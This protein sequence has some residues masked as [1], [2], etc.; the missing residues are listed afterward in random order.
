MKR[1]QY[2]DT[3]LVNLIARKEMS[4]CAIAREL[5]LSPG[6]VRRIANGRARQD[7]QPR[8]RSLVNMHHRLARRRIEQLKK[9][10]AAAKAA[11]AAKAAKSPKRDL[12]RGTYNDDLLVELLAE[13][14]LS[15]KAV[16]DRL[17][18]T[19]TMVG[20]LARGESRPHL[21]ERVARAFRTNV[22]KAKNRGAHRLL[23]LLNVHADH[24]T[25]DDESAR[26]C[27]EFL[28]RFFL[29][30]PTDETD[31][32]SADPPFANFLK[33]STDTRQRIAADLCGPADDDDSE[34]NTCPQ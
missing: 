34:V 29:E 19:A 17:G 10:L 12:K 3:Q 2:D 31:T 27:R 26:K 4:N 33:L 11:P 16:A 21:V 18:I 14:S 1:K 13:A 32:A 28:L 25:G 23:D 22:R 6:M 24:G 30:L 20:K 8:I 5:G 9:Q 15:Y 7:L